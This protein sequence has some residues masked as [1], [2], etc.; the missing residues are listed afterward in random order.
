MLKIYSVLLKIV[1]CSLNIPYGVLNYNMD[2]TEKFELLEKRLNCRLVYHDVQYRYFHTRLARCS[3]KYLNLHFRNPDRCQLSEA[4]SCIKHCVV[5]LRRTLQH[6]RCQVKLWRCRKG[7]VQLAAPV[8]SGDRL[9]GILFAGIWTR[10][11]PRIALREL[12]LLLPVIARGITAQLEELAGLDCSV[13]TLRKNV[14][15]FLEQHY[16]EDITLA[17]LAKHLS[18]S[19]S[20]TCHLVSGEFKKPFRKVLLDF[21]LEKAAAL[22][23]QERTRVNEAARL[24]GFK[25]VNYFSAAFRKYFGV[26]PKNWHAG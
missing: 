1:F 20:R 23:R 14:L 11:L 12:W 2:F 19:P 3:R 22:L 21:R 18:L 26:S 16:C 7:Y 4:A 17:D 8:F 24:C 15:D 13:S 9:A 6:E 25:S 5:K 10:P